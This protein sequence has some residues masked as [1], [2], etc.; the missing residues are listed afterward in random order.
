MAKRIV[1]CPLASVWLIS[2]LVFLA[3]IRSTDVLYFCL[4][5]HKCCVFFRDQPYNT[6]CSSLFRVAENLRFMVRVATMKI[7]AHPLHFCCGEIFVW[8]CCFSSKLSMLQC[9]ILSPSV[10]RGGWK[11]KAF[12][13]N[14]GSLVCS[15]L[16]LLVL[17]FCHSCSCQLSSFFV[18]FFFL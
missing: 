3:R 14:I 11:K 7:T 18:S 9:K 4:S 17:L 1:P 5:R 15:S 16:L 10:L 2:L 8:E 13:R 12:C 6:A